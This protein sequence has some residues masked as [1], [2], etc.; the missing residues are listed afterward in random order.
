MQN[1]QFVVFQAASTQE[2]AYEMFTQESRKTLHIGAA[3]F[4]EAQA[5]KC[6]ACGGGDFI[7]QLM[8]TSQ[9]GGMAKGEELPTVG[10]SKTQRPTSAGG[11]QGSGSRGGRLGMGRVH[12]V[13]RKFKSGG[14]QMDNKPKPVVGGPKVADVMES[15]A[16][17][18]VANESAMAA[19][20]EYAMKKS[21]YKCFILLPHN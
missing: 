8:I 4:L 19:G 3:Q 10:P 16:S 17:N 18:A 13:D 6:Q 20:M 9:K 5:H 14:P 7:T 21:L 11:G 1:S 2:T 15:K 12:Q